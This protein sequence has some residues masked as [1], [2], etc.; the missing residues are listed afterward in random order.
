MVV[1]L[2]RQIP[3]DIHRSV[4]CI[5]LDIRCHLLGIE[6]S[7]RGQLTCRTHE[8]FLREEV[9]RLGTKLTA[10]HILIEAVV[11]IDA[12]MAQMS[13]WSFQHTHLQVDRVADDILLSGVDG[14]ED[15]TIVVVEVRHGV[16]VLTESLVEQL[17]IVDVTFPHSQQIGEVS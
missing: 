10:H 6:E 16:V 3:V 2:L 7:H 15:V 1:G 4:L 13:L 14:R 5:R 8:G 11:T 12:N 17:L 9:S